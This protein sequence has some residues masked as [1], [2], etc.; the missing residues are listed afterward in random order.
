MWKNAVR[1]DRPQTT[2]C[3]A[4]KMRFAYWITKASIQTT[5]IYYLLLHNQFIP[6]YTVKRF[7]QNLH[8]LGQRCDLSVIP[9]CLAKFDV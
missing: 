1:P 4:E 9:I 5:H 2:I 3:G 8:K 7:T 6:F